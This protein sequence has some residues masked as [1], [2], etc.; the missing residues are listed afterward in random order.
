[1]GADDSEEILKARKEVDEV[2][3]K[4]ENNQDLKAQQEKPI[5]ETIENWSES[6][7]DAIIL[8][9]VS[10]ADEPIKPEEVESSK[11]IEEKLPVAEEDV[12]VEENEEVGVFKEIGRTLNKFRKIG[13]KAIGEPLPIKSAKGVTGKIIGVLDLLAMTPVSITLGAIKV[14]YKSFRKMGLRGAELADE[15]KLKENKGRDE[16]YDYSFDPRTNWP[17]LTVEIADKFMRILGLR[18]IS[19]LSNED[20]DNAVN[21][22]IEELL[23]DKSEKN[24]PEI[25][26]STVREE[27]ELTKSIE[28]A[29]SF[30]ELFETLRS[31]KEI[32]GTTID[33]KEESYDAEHAIRIIEGFRKKFNRDHKGLKYSKKDAKIYLASTNLSLQN[34]PNQEGLVEKIKELILAEIG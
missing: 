27:G 25:L 34:L 1:M 16:K 4:S 17:M 24:N 23:E 21:G 32:N 15:V 2:F 22:A 26:P 7:I 9:E 13:D 33:G 30:D 8:E 12:E 14:G 11:V 6:D 20:V 18:G 29:N 5:S 28:D 19:K 31:K 3:D 10:K